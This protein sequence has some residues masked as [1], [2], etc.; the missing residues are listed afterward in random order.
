MIHVYVENQNTLDDKFIAYINL[1]QK[2][3]IQLRIWRM[4]KC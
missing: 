2:T 3:N 4:F 1:I